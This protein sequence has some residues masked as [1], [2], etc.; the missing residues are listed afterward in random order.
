MSGA[1]SF[2]SIHANA[3][4]ADYRRDQRYTRPVRV[5][6]FLRLCYSSPHSFEFHVELHLQLLERLQHIS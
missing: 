1:R 5:V 4:I 3:L 6:D 2:L